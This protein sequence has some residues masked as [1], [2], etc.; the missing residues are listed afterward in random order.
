MNVNE[1][2]N[3]ILDMSHDEAT[4]DTDLQAKALQWLNSAYHEII[5]ELLP[6]LPRYLQQSEILTTDS[7][8]IATLTNNVFRMLRVVNRT[9]NRTLLEVDKSDILD[10]DPT[11]LQTGNPFRFWLE[12]NIL[13]V[14]PKAVVNIQAVYFPVVSD[15]VDAGA[16]ATILLP[17]NF[18]HALVWGGLVWSSTY[19]RAFSTQ[20]DLVLFQRKWDE[21]K[22]KI[23]LSLTAKPS[24]TLRVSPF[25]VV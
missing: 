14:H 19:E 13:H 12:N 17:V 25:D 22:Q 2:V 6:F 4:P 21:A 7:D 10:I 3:R 15:L 16:E 9:S 23:K 18:H 1:L 24:G 11:G 20:G 8:G 5:D